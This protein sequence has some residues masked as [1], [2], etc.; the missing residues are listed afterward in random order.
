LAVT[1]PPVAL[2]YPGLFSNR[3]AS[4]RSSI[5]WSGRAI[6]ALD[7]GILSFAMVKSLITIAM[8]GS[9]SRNSMQA[10]A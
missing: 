2:Q 8:L 9:V 7:R 5:Y 10:Y 3:G 1:L 6:A 4:L